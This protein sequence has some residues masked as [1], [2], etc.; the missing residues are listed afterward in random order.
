MRGFAEI[1]ALRPMAPPV[2]TSV[3]A[4]HNRHCFQRLLRLKAARFARQYS[5]YVFFQVHRYD[6]LRQ[7]N[8]H[9]LAKCQTARQR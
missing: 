4:R 3:C 1:K 5:R 6:A 8:R 7:A 9:P 2:D